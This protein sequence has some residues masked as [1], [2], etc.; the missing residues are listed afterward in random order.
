MLNVSDHAPFIN[1]V[2][3][4]REEAFTGDGY[5]N[6]HRPLECVS[7]F[8]YARRPGNNGG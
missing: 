2:S 4:V 6:I 1:G 7:A 3:L 5:Y 8:R